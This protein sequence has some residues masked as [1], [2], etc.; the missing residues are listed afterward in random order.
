MAESGYIPGALFTLSMWYRKQEL[1]KRLAIFFFGL[2]GGSAVGPLLASG[3][4]KLEGKGGITGWQYLFLRETPL[5]GGLS[6]RAEMGR[7]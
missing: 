6:S 5:P 2:F 4:L 3:I 1:A 7:N